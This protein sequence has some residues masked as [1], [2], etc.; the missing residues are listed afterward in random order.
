MPLCGCAWNATLR[1][2]KV[3]MRCLWFTPLILFAVAGPL[4]G[5]ETH[6][7]PATAVNYGVLHEWLHSGDPRLIAWAADFALRTHDTRIVAEMSALLE[8]W[9]VPQA[10]GGDESQAAQVRAVAAVLDTLIQEEVQVPIP[11]IDAIAGSFPAQ[12]TILIGRLPLSES[13]VTLQDWTYGA[14][15]TWT[16]RTLARIASM[17][18]AK[19]PRPSR[20]IW[21]RNDLGFVASVVAASEEELQITVVSAKTQH[22][23]YGSGTCGDYGASPVAPGWP[24]VYA[25]DLVEN[26]PQASAPI[27]VDLD[28][29]RIVSRR[30]EENRPWGSCYGVQWLDPSTRHRLIAHWL[31]V[32]EKE[33]SWQPVE[34][35]TIVWTDKA[36]YRQQLGE[37]IEAQ[38]KKLHATVEAL[39]QRGLMTDGETATVAP[40]L[41]V[42]VQC[43]IKP[44]PLI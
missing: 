17:L 2:S 5:Q 38:R 42:D 22:E 3:L 13:R 7:A 25:Y 1:Q 18:L 26:D 21:N 27:V 44:C 35:F 11:A 10:L 14:T 40:R 31:G 34:G 24:Q 6:I 37:I 9:T 36:A 28:G 4:P 32:Q 30:F 41:I 20:G 39:G 12:A 33:M 15:G 43:E 29:D 23:G 16:G 8:H 19:D